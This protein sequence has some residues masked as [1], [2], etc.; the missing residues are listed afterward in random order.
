M[1]D[2]QSSLFF[3]VKKFQSVHRN[4]RNIHGTAWVLRS[5]EDVPYLSFAFIGNAANIVVG[6]PVWLAA[7]ECRCSV[8][9][10]GTLG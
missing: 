5:A 7:I 9:I 8:R 3:R 6:V 1:F 4:N 10:P 2:S